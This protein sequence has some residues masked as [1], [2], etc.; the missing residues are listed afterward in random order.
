MITCR[1]ATQLVLAAEDRRIPLAGRLALRLHQGLC[2]NCRNF[3]RQIGLMREASARWR[4][5]SEE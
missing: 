4:R 3:A 2:G 5:Y 1:E